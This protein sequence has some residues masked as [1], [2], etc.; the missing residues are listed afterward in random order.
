MKGMGISINFQGFL[1]FP[2]KFQWKCSPYF[3]HNLQV[4]FLAVTVGDALSLTAR[5]TYDGD[6]S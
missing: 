6:L 4:Q 5:I 1:R 2:I 3:P